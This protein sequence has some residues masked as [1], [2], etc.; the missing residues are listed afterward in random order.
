M[1]RIGTLVYE[2]NSLGFSCSCPVHGSSVFVRLGKIPQEIIEQ[3]DKEGI[4]AS[5]IYARNLLMD[6][7][8]LVCPGSAFGSIKNNF[9]IRITVPANDDKLQDL[10]I[11][12]KKFQKY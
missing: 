7:G 9:Y 8:L 10:I 2:M 3:A 12:I 1:F 11:R 5:E 6:T 4:S